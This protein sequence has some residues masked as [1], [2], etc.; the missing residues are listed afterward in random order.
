[1]VIVFVLFWYLVMVSNKI[2]SSMD[3]FLLLGYLLLSNSSKDLF[4]VEEG[5]RPF[6]ARSRI[7]EW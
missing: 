6:A 4:G 7:F 2:S 1:M 5:L 3:I